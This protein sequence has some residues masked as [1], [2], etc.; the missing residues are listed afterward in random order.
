MTS[1]DLVLRIAVTLELAAL[2]TL[3]ALSP[4]AGLAARLGPLFCGSVIAFVVTSAARGKAIIQR[5]ADK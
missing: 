5:A 2:A 4:R 3:L 1:V